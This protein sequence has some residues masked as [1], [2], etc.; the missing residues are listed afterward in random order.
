M[1]TQESQYELSTDETPSQ[2]VVEA[3]ANAIDQ[4]PLELVPLADAIDPD[5]LDAM[6]DT[7]NGEPSAVTVT[8]EY[9]GLEVMAT[10]NEIQLTS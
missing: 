7:P 5:A 9:C 4:S 1:S 3:V 6:L 8:F 2:A 10:P